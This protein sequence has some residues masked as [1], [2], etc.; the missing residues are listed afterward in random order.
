MIRTIMLRST[1][2][3]FRWTVRSLVRKDTAERVAVIGEF[4]IQGFSIQVLHAVC[5]VENSTQV[6]VLAEKIA[7]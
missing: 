4:F 1:G 6:A 5:N 2:L 7:S 3:G